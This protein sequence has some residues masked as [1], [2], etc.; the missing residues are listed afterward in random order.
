MPCL[1]PLAD[2]CTGGLP[3]E[4]ALLFSMQRMVFLAL[5][6]GLI[7]FTRAQS[8]PTW[9]DDIAPIVHTHCAH[10]HH[11]GGAGPFP[12]ITYEDVFFT[13]NMDVHVIQDGEMPPWP[14]DPS[15]QHF[16]GENVL[17]DQ[18]K[19]LF[20]EWYETG[21]AYGD[22]EAT[23]ELPTFGPQ[24]S[25]LES[26]DFVADFPEYTLQSNAEEYRWFVVPTDFE[27]TRYIQAVE[28][29]PGLPA[30]VHH[31]DIFVD[32]TG[33]SMV[34]DVL[35][36]LPGFNGSTGWPTNTTYINA[37]QPGA[38]P[39]RYPDGWGIP[40]TPGADLVIE[41]HYGP[42]FG[43]EV[44]DTVMN[45]E[46]VDE[47]E[48]E[49]RPISVGWLLGN[50]A[51][52]DGPL[53]IPPDV[54]STFHQEAVLFNSDKSLLSICPHM[55]LLGKS[56]KVWMETPEGDSIPLIDIPQW[57]FEWQFYYRFLSPV[58]VP[59]GT[60]FKSEGEFDNTIWN[61]LNPNNP[62][63]VVT[64]GSLTSDEMFLTYFIWADY[65]EGDEELVFGEVEVSTVSPAEAIP[66]LK[67]WPTLAEST[68][69]VHHEFPRSLQA[70]VRTLEGKWCW[71]GT[72][73][74]GTT[75][76]DVANWPP[77]LYVIQVGLGSAREIVQWVKP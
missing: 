2:G 21:M 52:T 57:Q 26:V 55:H 42:D 1:Q 75:A 60:V 46:W 34:L 51:M 12:L 63:E 49:V 54:I 17:S 43:G 47:P 33:E 19:S 41:I 5:V 72:L 36:P 59:A 53:V 28:V 71:S 40:V 27:E 35:D 62:P 6:V 31:A 11:N 69:R 25:L 50:A 44:D 15:Y 24:G 30:A 56:Y 14:A 18:D 76:L 70:V 61:P 68:L 65:E 29:I 39:A 66:A 73:S 58:H 9:V 67:V 32:A 22:E 4:D 38:L 10:C 7:S 16:V 8:L 37:W 3:N 23:V 13:A 20:V 48:E 64:Y 77:G 74:P 45:L